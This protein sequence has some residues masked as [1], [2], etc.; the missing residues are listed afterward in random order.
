MAEKLAKHSSALEG[1]I[2]VHIPPSHEY[3]HEHSQWVSVS[4]Y[5]HASEVR[6]KE[7]RIENP[8][9][10]TFHLLLLT[11]EEEESSHVAK[12]WSQ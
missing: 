11:K 7:K 3:V 6:H 5:L 8:V 10:Y 12:K 2:N 1:T 9:M 4:E